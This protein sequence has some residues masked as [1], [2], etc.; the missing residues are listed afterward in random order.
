MKGVQ[1]MQDVLVIGGGSCGL[2]ATWLLENQQNLRVTLVEKSDRLGGHI[3]T[4]RYQCAACLI[5]HQPTPEEVARVQSLNDILFIHEGDEYRMGFCDNQ[6]DYQEAV[7]TDASLL[8]FLK[9]QKDGIFPVQGDDIE[10]LNTQLRQVGSCQRMTVY[11]VERGAEFIGSKKSYPLLNTIFDHLQVQSKPFTL[12]EQFDGA[13]GERIFL[14]PVIHGVEYTKKGVYFSVPFRSAL[15]VT[16]DMFDEVVALFN[17]LFV[18]ED[19]ENAL[20]P[21]LQIMTLKAFI[22]LFIQKGLSESIKKSREH[23]SN[24]FLYPLLAA[25]WGVSIKDMEEFAAHYAMNYLSLGKT[26]LDVPEGL[27]TYIQ[28]MQQECTH[29]DIK[30]NT[31]IKKLE[32]VQTDVEVRYKAKLIDGSYLKDQDGKEALFQQVIMAIPANSIYAIMPDAHELSELKKMLSCVRYYQ[33]SI[34]THRDPSYLSHDQY[35]VHTIA[36]RN[37]GTVTAANTT[38]KY[39]NY[40]GE[41]PVFRSWVLPGQ[42]APTNLIDTIYYQH[43][44]INLDYYQAQQALHQTQ[45]LLP[46][47]YFGNIISGFNDSNESTQSVAIRIAYEIYRQLSHEKGT[48]DVNRFT[49]FKEYLGS[50]QELDALS[51]QL[52]AH[53]SSAAMAGQK[54]PSP[55]LC[56]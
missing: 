37:E 16:S 10:T 49:L 15:S 29:A 41:V 11:V 33:T 53:A 56:P 42:A 31:E 23:F 14:P 43:P 22:D 30:T 7:I 20:A 8:A 34:M 27:D 45:G 2:T 1:A 44:Y 46:G 47:L 50:L 21:G 17:T 5:S 28:K 48:A 32:L 54:A 40:D 24:T 6:Y 55:R 13:D 39:R 38:C 3:D 51:D 26:W 36:K 52:G 19:A 35:V 4:K 9:T 25:S 12:T 18:I